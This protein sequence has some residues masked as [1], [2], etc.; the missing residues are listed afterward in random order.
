VEGAT[1]LPPT[2]D[3]SDSLCSAESLS[4][5]EASTLLQDA[6]AAIVIIDTRT[7]A[8]YAGGHIP[9]AVNLSTQD[10]AFWDQVGELPLDGTYLLYCR[11]GS[12][13]RSM[14]HRMPSSLVLGGRGMFRGRPDALGPPYSAGNPE[15]GYRVLPSWWMEI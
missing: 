15:P 11:T 5:V 14:A 7:P 9:G 4:S 10:A 2:D 1:P 8:E 13:T 12:T 6:A 3:S